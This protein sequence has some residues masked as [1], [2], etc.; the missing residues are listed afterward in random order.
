MKVVSVVL[1]P[2]PALACLLFS[3]SGLLLGLL[4]CLLQFAAAIA[5]LMTFALWISNSA[6]SS[7]DYIIGLGGAATFVLL[8][9]V[10]LFGQAIVKTV[11]ARIVG[12]L[13]AVILAPVRKQKVS[14]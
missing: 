9:A 6:T 4:L 14:E 3:A 10:L 11:L 1:L 12:T 7:M 2:V 8:S 13:I 5:V